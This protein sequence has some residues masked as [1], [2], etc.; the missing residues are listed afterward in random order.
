MSVDVDAVNE[1]LNGLV[2]LLQAVGMDTGDVTGI[3]KGLGGGSGGIP[4]ARQLNDEQ[5]EAI[6]KKLQQAQA[7]APQIIAAL[8]A[9]AEHAR[10]REPAAAVFVYLRRCP[11]HS[12]RGRGGTTLRRG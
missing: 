10:P 1:R 9:H 3:S 5:I 2:T 8:E 6:I 4:D 7:Q 11:P 12:Q